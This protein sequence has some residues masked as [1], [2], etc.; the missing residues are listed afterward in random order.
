MV[1]IFSSSLTISYFNFP[2]FHFVDKC[3]GKPMSPWTSVQ[4]ALVFE[5]AK[6]IMYIRP[7]GGIK[8][9]EHMDWKAPLMQTCT[10]YQRHS[11]WKSCGA[12]IMLRALQLF[13]WPNFLISEY[14]CPIT[15]HKNLL[16]PWIISTSQLFKMLGHINIYSNVPSVSNIS[17]LCICTVYIVLWR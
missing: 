17:V 11:T 14:K 6:H 4:I 2:A 16:L 15:V 10:T 9:K 13:L 5:I 1:S 3:F 12:E 7:L 8:L